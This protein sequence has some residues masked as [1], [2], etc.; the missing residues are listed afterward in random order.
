MAAVAAATGGS[1]PVCTQ[2]TQRQRLLPPPGTHKQTWELEGVTAATLAAA[3]PGEPLLSPEFSAGGRR[4]QLELFLGGMRKQHA[5]HISLIL[6]LATADHGGLHAAHRGGGVLRD[7]L[8]LLRERRG[9]GPA[10]QRLLQAHF[11]R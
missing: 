7:P 3:T 9:R 2:A 8:H 10:R 5:G 4:R 6:H 1:A 11:A